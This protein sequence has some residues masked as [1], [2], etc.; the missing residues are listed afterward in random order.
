MLEMKYYKTIW[1]V[2]VMKYGKIREELLDENVRIRPLVKK[3]VA[4][5]DQYANRIMN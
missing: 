2:A 4:I 3:D 5:L 1:E